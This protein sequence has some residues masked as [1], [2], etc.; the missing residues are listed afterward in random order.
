[1]N[2][3][4]ENKGFIYEFGKFVL[5][6]QERVLLADGKQVHLTDKVFDTLLLLIENNGRLLTKDEMITSIWEE[7][8]VEESNLA[9]NISRLRKILNADGVELIETLPK[10]GYR[11]R[12]EVAQFDGATNLLVRRN[13]RVKITQIIEEDTE[14]TRRGA[15]DA[16]N[17]SAALLN[18]PAS[19]PRLPLLS[20]FRLLASGAALILVAVGAFW[21]A[22]RRAKTLPPEINSIAVLP[23]KSL[24]AEESNK[25]LGLGLT[26]ALISRLGSLRT[27]TV[28]PTSAV[29]KY[30]ETEADALEIGRR[31]N[32]DTVL[33]GTIQQSADRL[34]VN[35]RLLRVADGEQL[36]T[37]KF[38][39]PATNIFALQ[40]ALS[41]R[42]ARTLFFELTNAEQTQFARRQTE[43][44][45]AYE[46][47]LRGRFYQNQ[48]TE[49]GLT[50]AVEFYEQAIALDRGFADAHAGLADALLILYNFGLRPPDEIVPRA[51]QSLNRALQLNPNLSDAYS[52]LALIQFLS[53][54]DWLAAEQ[55]LHRAIEL[56]PNNADAFLRY[57]YF[58]MAVGKF[59]EALAKLNKARQLN[60]L[61]PIVQADIGLTH[62]CARRYGQAI[63]QLE[64]VV[65][66]NPETSLP[67]WFL[68]S[69]YDA[70]EEPEKAFAEY[71]RALEREGA[72]ELAARLE[73]IKQSNGEQSAYQIWLEQNLKMR[74]QGNFP[75]INIAF[76]CAALKN[77]QETLTW[78][79]TAFDEREPTIWQIK[80]LPNYDFIRDEARFQEILRKI[81]IRG[82]K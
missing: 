76:L 19:A 79:E 70:N 12:A 78:L 30:V 6:P 34:R 63:E 49:S 71:L 54:L 29:A 20:A 57:G 42:I 37:E 74:K 13:L 38:D 26:D 52:S 25:A 64:K 61:S 32:V 17:K 14:E 46:K 55:S 7:S 51:K 73:K 9:K 23:L 77:R 48:N 3:A 21:Y 56:N 45:E 68:G 39:E 47:Y 60:P 53:E 80:H 43:N 50:K 5:D 44:V 69:S 4:A 10:R 15:G 82:E 81:N 58:L 66:E 62:L 65:A 24:T 27:I 31:L 22:N 16:E 8:F 1:M 67:R 18:V 75:A 2:E 11:F 36:W 33:E 40:D 59:D 72:A 41:N 28:R 35:A